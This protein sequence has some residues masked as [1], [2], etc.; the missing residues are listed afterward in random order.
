MHVVRYLVDRYIRKKGWVGLDIPLSVL[1][2]RCAQKRQGGGQSDENTD[3][4]TGTTTRAIKRRARVP[5]ANPSLPPLLFFVVISVVVDGN[6]RVHRAHLDEH[7][8]E[9]LAGVVDE[10]LLEAVAPE[11]LEPED[12]DQGDRPGS[13]LVL[14]AAASSDQTHQTHAGGVS[15]YVYRV[16]KA[17]HPTLN[18]R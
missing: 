14:G 10:E 11:R 5:N 16:A 7:L 6:V 12:V 13:L 18:I 9:L 2:V 17:K 1:S 3:V 15:Y 8:L 4:L